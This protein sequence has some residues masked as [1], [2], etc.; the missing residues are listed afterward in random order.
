MT[1]VIGWK[2]SPPCIVRARQADDGKADRATLFRVV[3]YD[4]SAGKLLAVPTT[5]PDEP[6]TEFPCGSM[7]VSEDVLET[8]YLFASG[9]DAWAFAAAAGFRLQTVAKAA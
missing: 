9:T 8:Y 6:P 4:A 3:G 7:S 2:G 1:A 5:A